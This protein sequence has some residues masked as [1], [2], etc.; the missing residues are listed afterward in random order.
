M[1]KLIAILGIGL[2]LAP[3]A[4]AQLDIVSFTSA[5][6]SDSDSEDITIG[7]SFVVSSPVKVIG[8]SAFVNN[9]SGG[10][11]GNTPVG[12]W[13]SSGS[14]L[15]SVTVLSGTADPLTPDGF[16]RYATL[17]SPVTLSDGTYYVGAY[18]TPG[19]DFTYDVG[20]LNT[21]SGV[22]YSAPQ[23]GYGSSLAFP[24]MEANPANGEFGGNVVVGVVPE[25]STYIAGAMMLLPFGAGGLRRLCKNRTQIT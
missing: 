2:S 6:H 10:V 4:W 15:A 20:G 8:L 13:N 7:Y 22:S 11:N 19:I 9:G 3:G 14:S 25:P 23:Y 21:L 1:R 16:F 24:S 17:S 12:L 5:P 18:V